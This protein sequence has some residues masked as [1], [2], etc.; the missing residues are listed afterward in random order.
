MSS[1]NHEDKRYCPL[2]QKKESRSECS[3]GERVW[4]KVS[5]KDEEYSMA[6]SE[7]K[8]IEDA[9]NRLKSTVGKGEGN[10]EAWVQSK[11]TK[12]A[13]Y[14]DTAADYL[15]SG[16]H[17][18]KESKN[19]L[20]DPRT[21]IKKSKGTGALTPDAAKQLGPKAIELQKKRAAE[22]SLP[23]IE[24]KLVDKILNDLNE[25][26]PCWK[27]YIQVGMKKKGKK[28]VPNCVP[29]KKGVKKARGYKKESVDEAVRIPSRNGNNIFVT[30]SWR[31]KYYT[32]QLF[33]PQAKIPS[34][35]DIQYEIQ[36]IYPNSRVI[37]HRVADI[38][39]GEPMIYAG[40]NA[41][42]LGSDKNYV[43][44]MG[45]EVEILDEKK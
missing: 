33:F 25:E 7:I 39:P 40:G 11:I 15:Q 41:G 45:E 27:G 24:E 42:K 10:L 28:E 29:I 1:H 6:R 26:D 34:R 16:E 19:P 8:T 5:V 12:A 32:I 44:P 4:D 36:K 35:L 18:V 37:T 14:I 17:S 13:D 30:L 31:G 3:Y 9:L 38:K 2:C 23:K 43:K 22:V 21:Q 20:K